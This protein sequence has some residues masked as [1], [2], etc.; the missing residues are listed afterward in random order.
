MR[1]QTI[2]ECNNNNI[3]LKTATPCQRQNGRSHRRAGRKPSAKRN[4]VLPPQSVRE[5]AGETRSAL[6]IIPQ[7]ACLAPRIGIRLAGLWNISW[8]LFP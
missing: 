8:I 7:I 5:R 3:L 4:S 2:H 6:I 1:L